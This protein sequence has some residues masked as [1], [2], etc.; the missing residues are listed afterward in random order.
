MLSQVQRTRELLDRAR[1]RIE[2]CDRDRV[3]ALLRAAVDMQTRAETATRESRYLAAL[4][5]TLS[6]RERGLR[7]LR[8][9]N[10]EEN[11]QDAAERA[12][13]RTD[14]LIARAREM[15]ADSDKNRAK[16]VLGRAE[17]VQTEGHAQLRAGHSEA[18]LT[19]SARTLT[20]RAIR[21]AGGAR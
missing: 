2:D 9:C 18:A 11:V 14:E 15:I 10:M 20:Y 17:R 12:L 4:Q 13:Q 3:R 16:E 21:L 6:A 19:Q 7:A 5:L 1:E 8:L